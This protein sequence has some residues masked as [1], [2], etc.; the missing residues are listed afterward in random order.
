M[1]A[2]VLLGLAVVEVPTKKGPATDDVV[3]LRVQPSPIANPTVLRP[4]SQAGRR[5]GQGLAETTIP[6][7]SS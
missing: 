5:V 4:A 1:E 7:T 2:A 3:R 6:M